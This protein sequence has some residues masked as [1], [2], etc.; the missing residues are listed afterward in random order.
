METP[1]REGKEEGELGDKYGADSTCLLSLRLSNSLLYC[2]PVARRSWEDALRLFFESSSEQNENIK[3][4]KYAVFK[5]SAGVN[6]T[7]N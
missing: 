6:K 4:S 7:F 2:P 3:P 5:T 1:Q